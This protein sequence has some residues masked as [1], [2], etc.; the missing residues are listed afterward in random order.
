[1]SIAVLSSANLSSLYL[2]SADLS[3]ALARRFNHQPSAYAARLAISQVGLLTGDVN[4]KYI[5][6]VPLTIAIIMPAVASR[7]NMAELFMAESLK[8][9]ALLVQ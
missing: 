4:S 3:I 6:N 8:P 9:K 7:R 1:M 5:E 2:S